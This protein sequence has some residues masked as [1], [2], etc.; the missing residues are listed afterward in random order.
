MRRFKG[1]L[2]IV[3]ILM[4]FAI[5]AFSA[6]REATLGGQDSSGNYRFTVDSDG[7]LAGASTST[8]KL[9]RAYEVI[10]ATEEAVV[11]A[12]NGKIMVA[13]AAATTTFTLPAAVVGMEFTFVA[14]AAQTVSIDPS[15]TADTITYL[16]LNAG[17]EIDS[18]GAIGDS[19]TLK[20]YTA[21]TWIPVNMG[22]SAWSDGGTS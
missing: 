19:V 21:N 12:D 16:T 1:L 3:A 22:S 9:S 5:P 7:V 11:A 13:T 14:G 18:A 17:D 8:T 20:C 4:V 10:T 6:T 2:L 15:T